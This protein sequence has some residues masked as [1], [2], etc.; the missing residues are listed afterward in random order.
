MSINT[1]PTA[2]LTAE[3]ATAVDHS[4]GSINAALQELLNAALS[5]LP[6]QDQEKINARTDL[7]LTLKR[8][9][10]ENIFNK[11]MGTLEGVES[12][13]Q[14]IRRLIAGLRIEDL[15][16]IHKRSV[17]G[18]KREFVGVPRR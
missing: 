13:E 12:V 6:K 4:H 5:K 17:E 11:R 9:L 16:S 8:V 18:L 7:D 3:A 2:P 1:Q 15:Q 10:A 14:G